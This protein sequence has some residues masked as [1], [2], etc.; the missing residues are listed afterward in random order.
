[1]ALPLVLPISVSDIETEFEAPV[2]T[3]LSEFIKGG[4]FVPDNSENV[5]VPTAL[6]LSIS[7]F[8]GAAN[9][10]P[11]I[12][13]IPQDLAGNI[14]IVQIDGG[15]YVA[16]EH[17]LGSPVTVDPDEEFVI[18]VTVRC[19]TD[20][21]DGDQVAPQ[22]PGYSWARERMRIGIGVQNFVPNFTGV[23]LA[24]FFTSATTGYIARYMS[25]AQG[26][27]RSNQEVAGST[28]QD[29]PNTDYGNF[30]IPDGSNSLRIR[31]TR[32]ASYTPSSSVNEWY[33][34]DWTVEIFQRGSFTTLWKGIDLQYGGNESN[35]LTWRAGGPLCL[36]NDE[37]FD[38]GECDLEFTEIKAFVGGT[39]IPDP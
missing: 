3:P 20:F 19:N 25:Q 2:G 33:Q 5:N 6:P 22:L 35:S 38:G 1:M 12:L 32:G 39:V 21:Q 13:T 27:S 4:T 34:S 18:D 23:R 8:F 36:M 30:V 31:V 7:D 26:S 10:S 37:Y 11:P 28:Y 15:A 17:P 9:T 24:I 29:Q 16:A 14:N